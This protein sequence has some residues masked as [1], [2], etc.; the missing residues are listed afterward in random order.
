[1][2]PTKWTQAHVDELERTFPELTDETSTDKL[3]LNC[4]KRTVVL[5]VQGKLLAQQKKVTND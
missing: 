5:Y 1:M 2:I 3:L 4:G